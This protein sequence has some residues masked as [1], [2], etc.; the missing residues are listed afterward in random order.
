M[1]GVQ[2]FAQAGIKRRVPGT[3]L[4]PLGTAV[5]V[6]V[7][8]VPYVV[9]HCCVV[10]WERFPLRHFD[11]VPNHGKRKGTKRGIEGKKGQRP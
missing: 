3:V 11:H 5:P 1:H 6:P 7:A 9:P 4:V 2:L 8:G 10:S